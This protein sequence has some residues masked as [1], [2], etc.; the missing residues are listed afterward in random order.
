VM[1]RAEQLVKLGWADRCH[2][3]MKRKKAEKK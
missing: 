2:D 1:V 3:A